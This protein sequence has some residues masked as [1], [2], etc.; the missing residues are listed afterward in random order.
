LKAQN[1]IKRGRGSILVT[2][3]FL[4][5]VLALLVATVANDSMQTLRSVSQSGRDTQAKYAAYA[6]MELVMNALRQDPRFIGDEITRP[7]HGKKVGKLDEL[8]K[9]NYEVL[10]WNNMPAKDDAPGSGPKDPIPG[11]NGVM[12]QPGTVYMV[13]TGTDTVR[14]EEVVLTTMAGTARRVKPV[15]EDAAYART[16]MI[17]KG[18]VL[19]DAW[20]SNGGWTEYVQGE[21]PSSGGLIGGSSGSNSGGN[22]NGNGGGPYGPPP[23]T[24]KDY[25]ATLGTDSSMGRT[26]RLLSGAKLNGHFRIGP[27]V[28]DAGA[29]SEDSGSG[30]TS[31]VPRTRGGTADGE[32]TTISY[33]VSTATDPVTQ[34]AGVAPEDGGPGA[35]SPTGKYHKLD[36][37]S[38]EMPRFTAPYDADDL[39]PPPILNNRSS[40]KYIPPPANSPPGTPGTT[41]YVPPDPVE[42]DPGGYESVE[43]PN[44]QTLKLRPGVYYFK[45]GMEVRGKIEVSGRDPVIVFIGKKAVFDNAEINEDGATSALQLCFTDEEKDPDKLDALVDKLLPDFELPTSVSGSTT[46]TTN[47]RLSAVAAAAAATGTTGGAPSAASLPAYVRSIIAPGADSTDPDSAEGASVLEVRGSKVF[48]TIAG[49]NLIVEGQGGEIYGGVMANIFRVN[50]TDIHQDLSLKGSNLMNAGGWALEG[51]HQLR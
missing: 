37:K 31:S 43:V 21:F 51:V 35:G 18:D 10:I 6:G 7:N 22:G 36:D 5:C 19:V 27:G 33:G 49:K 15:F 44:D 17:L 39:D 4:V 8:N 14:N 38:T 16:K 47:P 46:S 1:K 28:D 12:V 11:P 25:K 40:T 20:D 9:V 2:L 32:S 30:S 24:V 48:A 41:Q 23:P 26:L 50:G 45:E 13:S 42:L 34:I 29:F 3:L